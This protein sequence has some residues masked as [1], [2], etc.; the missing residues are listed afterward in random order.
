[1]ID[2]W[3]EPLRGVIIVLFTLVGLSILPGLPIWVGLVIISRT[4]RKKGAIT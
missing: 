4:N 2:T 1:M 3:S